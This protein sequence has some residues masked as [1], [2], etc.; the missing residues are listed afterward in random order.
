MS[1]SLVTIMMTP[2]VAADMFITSV[3][4]YVD[5]VMVR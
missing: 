2:R 5:S 3:K 1:K 4:K